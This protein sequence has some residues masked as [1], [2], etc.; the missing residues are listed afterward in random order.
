MCC[1]CSTSPRC[2]R[3][4]VLILTSLA[5]LLG[6]CILGI[7]LFFYFEHC[8]KYCILSQLTVPVTLMIIG[9]STLVTTSLG[10]I[11]AF[12][13]NRCILRTF[14]V[15]IILVFLAH[16][17]VGITFYQMREELIPMALKELRALIDQAERSKK[18]EA[19]TMMEKI[20]NRYKCCGGD[21][22][23]DWKDE[24]PLSCCVNPNYLDNTCRYPGMYVRGCASSM[25]RHFEAS[26]RIW[27]YLT[28]ILFFVEFLLVFAVSQF[29]CQ[30]PVYDRLVTE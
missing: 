29:L 25:Y 17:G 10:Y 13:I 21:G 7:G 22:Q 3:T 4:T 1:R 28:I 9:G 16:I 14:A 6:L 8:G 26:T 23:K 30:L 2:W 5:F 27:F 11:G 15:I 20:Q 19:F 24:V 18:S 12:Y